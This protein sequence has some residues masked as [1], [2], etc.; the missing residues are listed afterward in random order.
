[1]L[2]LLLR[3]KLKNSHDYFKVI[4]ERETRWGYRLLFPDGKLFRDGSTPEI[5]TTRKVAYT[6]FHKWKRRRKMLNICLKKKELTLF[7][8]FWWA[9]YWRR[10]EA[11][12]AICKDL[13]L[14]PDLPHYEM[15]N[16]DR[17]AQILNALD[18]ADRY[19][20]Q[21]S[22]LFMHVSIKDLGYGIDLFT[23]FVKDMRKQEIALKRRFP[24]EYNMYFNASSPY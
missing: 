20:N 14:E 5:K 24:K 2:N 11:L 4:F 3:V 22:T 8:D 10:G 21:F 1:M 12:R 16:K 7:T 9:K 6:N 18:Q 23:D 19:Y 17:A 13:V 15:T